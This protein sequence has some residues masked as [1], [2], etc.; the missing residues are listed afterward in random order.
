MVT[1]E[2]HISVLKILQ[3]FAVN[4]KKK[5]KIE[6]WLNGAGDLRRL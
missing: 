4:V 5:I 1:E 2:V 6:H 3:S